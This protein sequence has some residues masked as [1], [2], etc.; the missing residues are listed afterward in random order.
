MRFKPFF[1]LRHWKGNIYPYFILDNPHI[2]DY[3]IGWQM[4]LVLESLNTVL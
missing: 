1:S 4:A 3:W 2:I